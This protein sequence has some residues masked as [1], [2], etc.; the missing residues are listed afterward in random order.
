MTNLTKRDRALLTQMA[1]LIII[2][3]FIQLLVIGYVF[4]S[5]YEGRKDLVASQRAGCKRGKLDRAAN[6]E[7]WRIAEVARSSTGDYA[8]AARY[9]IIAVGLEDRSAINCEDAYPKASIFP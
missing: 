8:V 6:A 2:G 7:G 3:M 4:Y 9:E 1:I 5:S